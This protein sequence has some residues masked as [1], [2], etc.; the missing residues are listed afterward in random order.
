LN[1]KSI[2]LQNFQS[3]HSTHIEPAPPGQLTVITGPSDSGKTAIIRALKWLLYNQ[4]AGADFMRTGASMVRIS[5]KF[6]DGNIVTRERTAATNRYKILQPGAEKPEVFEGFGATVPLEIQEITGV[7]TVKIA[8]LDLMLNLSEQLDGPFLGQKSISS[9]ARAKILGKLAG[10]EE[11]DVAATETGR[12]LYRRN[13]D[14]KRLGEEIEELEKRIEKFAWIEEL[15]ERI[16]KLEQLLAGIKDAQARRSALE[17]LKTRLAEIEKQETSIRAIL[18]QWKELPRIEATVSR[19][20][21]ALER[22]KRLKGLSERLNSIWL[23]IGYAEATLRRLQ[24]L[25]DAGHIVTRTEKELARAKALHSIRVKL[26]QIDADLKLC[27]VELQKPRVVNLERLAAAV[28]KVEDAAERAGTLA[29]IKGRL[30]Q[31]DDQEPRLLKT[32]VFYDQRIPELEAEYLRELKAA[33][34][35]PTCGQS[36]AGLSE[37]ALK[38]V[39]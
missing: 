32:T 12:D 1:I 8:D 7:R 6:A 25:E 14:E 26:G 21:A 28:K 19:A 15:G 5:V 17:A 9:P 13:Q 33:K 2:E 35:C 24:V 30:A 22:L 4:P 31:I 37:F 11:I 18:K 16:A 3:H 27:R 10:T 23:S 36:V 34:I 39:V 20:E 29:I 38:E